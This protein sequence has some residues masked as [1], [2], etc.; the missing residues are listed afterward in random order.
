MKKQSKKGQ[1]RQTANEKRGKKEQKRPTTE[2]LSKKES[3]RREAILKEMLTNPPPEV[4]ET[5]RKMQEAYKHK[6]YPQIIFSYRHQC[7]AT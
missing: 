3:R 2:E 4:R 6:K 1:K 7:Q 5:M